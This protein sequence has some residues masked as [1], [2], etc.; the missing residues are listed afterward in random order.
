MGSPRKYDAEFYVV[1]AGV[2]GKTG[3]APNLCDHECL[4]FA[5]VGDV[6]TNAEI[7]HR[8]ATVYSSRGAIGNLGFNEVFLVFVIL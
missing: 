8:A 6:G 1:L 7:D 2:V 4:D 3:G 5:G